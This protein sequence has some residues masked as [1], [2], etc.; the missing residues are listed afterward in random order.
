MPGDERKVLVR[1]HRAK[2]ADATP[3]RI[4]GGAVAAGTIPGMVALGTLAIVPIPAVPGLGTVAVGVLVGGA[5]GVRLQAGGG[6]MRHGALVGLVIWSVGSC[7]AL[8]GRHAGPD[9]LASEVLLAIVQGPGTAL[10][11]AGTATILGSVGAR[12][13]RG[14]NP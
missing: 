7:V 3:G 1:A 12:L 10:L 4:D 13:G 11:A 5:V 8:A 14:R 2:L 9:A 6:P